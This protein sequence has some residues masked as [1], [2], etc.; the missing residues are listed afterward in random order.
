MDTRIVRGAGRSAQAM[1]TDVFSTASSVGVQP[2]L[3]GIDFSI[4]DDENDVNRI[5]IL[6]LEQAQ[7]GGLKKRDRMCTALKRPLA[8][9]VVDALPNP[10][11]NLGEKYDILC[12]DMQYYIGVV[13]NLME[14][15]AT[16]HFPFWAHKFDYHG[17][18]RELYIASYGLFTV[19]AG[20]NVA[21]NRYSAR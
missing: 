3:L 21:S 10:L 15:Y 20:L 19:P 17:D 2:S 16:I 11:V 18:V 6:D 5:D 9:N 12:E 13:T 1:N 8:D 4:D 7:R 14:N